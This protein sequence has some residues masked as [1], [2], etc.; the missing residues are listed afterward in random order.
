MGNDRQATSMNTPVEEGP[1]TAAERKFLREGFVLPG[2]IIRKR[3]RAAPILTSPLESGLMQRRMKRPEQIGNRDDACLT[4]DSDAYG[5]LRI[6]LTADT[7]PGVNGLILSA[8]GHLSAMN[9][10]HCCLE[11]RDA[12]HSN[13]EPLDVELRA[14]KVR[15]ELAALADS[16]DTCSMKLTHV[17]EADCM[18]IEGRANLSKQ[19]QKPP[20]AHCLP[21]TSLACVNGASSVQDVKKAEIG[22]ALLRIAVYGK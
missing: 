7:C 22:R 2:N 1:V 5:R 13:L 15:R 20:Q 3:D 16:A 18:V 10:S 6:L 11:L 12:V 14:R 19:P 21:S 17:G 9:L 4:P 8:L